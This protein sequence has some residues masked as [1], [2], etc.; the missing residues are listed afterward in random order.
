MENNY[1][2]ICDCEQLLIHLVR[3]L[4]KEEKITQYQVN[5]HVIVLI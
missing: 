3:Q 2:I 5:T 1:S 4:T